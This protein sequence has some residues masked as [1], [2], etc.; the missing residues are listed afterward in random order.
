LNDDEGHE[1]AGDAGRHPMLITPN[2]PQA[3]FGVGHTGVRCDIINGNHG[4]GNV[5]ANLCVRPHHGQDGILEK[6]RQG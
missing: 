3:Q 1:K 2:K 6:S 5:G 4:N